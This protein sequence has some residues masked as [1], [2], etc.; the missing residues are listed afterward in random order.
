MS[1]QARGRTQERRG[2]RYAPKGKGRAEAM[3]TASRSEPSGSGPTN[4]SAPLPSG[5]GDKRTH[6]NTDSE[7]DSD[8]LGAHKATFSQIMRLGT[9]NFE[10]QVLPPDEPSPATENDDAS[11]RAI[12]SHS[13]AQESSGNASSA[14]RTSKRRRLP[15]PVS[16]HSRSRYERD[17]WLAPPL[18]E[19]T[20]FVLDPRVQ[21]LE[22]ELERTQRQLAYLEDSRQRDLARAYNEGFGAGWQSGSSPSAAY[23]NP[24]ERYSHDLHRAMEES[25]EARQPS[26]LYQREPGPSRPST[27]DASPYSASRHLTVPPHQRTATQ[28]APRQRAPPREIPPELAVPTL[29]GTEP[30]EWPD[31]SRLPD[32]L[33]H[34]A[35]IPVAS[36]HRRNN[37]NPSVAL[38]PT[39]SVPIRVADATN[40][41]EFWLAVA[42]GRA[43]ANV[44]EVFVR[45]HD[46]SPR[47]A[48]SSLCRQA[49]M[50]Y[51]MTRHI[52]GATSWDRHLL[53][54]FVVVLAVFA[55]GRFISERSWTR[56]LG[57]DIAAYR[58]NHPGAEL[59]KNN[60]RALLPFA[61]HPSIAKP[62][63][64]IAMH[65]PP[66]NSL[67]PWRVLTDWKASEITMLLRSARITSAA[68]LQLFA[69]ADLF[70]RS[71]V[72]SGPLQ[73]IN[74]EGA[75]RGLHAAPFITAEF[76]TTSMV[77]DLNT[78]ETKEADH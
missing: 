71:R 46:H 66:P 59:P 19:R 62:S 31:P 74:Y 5:W 22:A 40:Y 70:I 76:D 77:A 26:S 3:P 64:G 25:R 12:G 36:T 38:I 1:Q 27:H 24:N 23:N 75:G 50:G 15:S 14:S 30:S 52:A 7:S 73:G 34:V 69:Y 43:G 8:D 41:D 28:R 29:S 32:D 39:G 57:D 18:P 6:Y 2:G 72:A 10:T 42:F 33:R 78:G 37:D 58:R 68:M 49:A 4:Q 47:L 65:P 56:I 55:Q 63:H 51:V 20:S 13:S 35:C 60:W 67:L 54:T 21:A 16:S 9:P 53:A 45:L 61:T 17:P 48:S 44:P 11:D